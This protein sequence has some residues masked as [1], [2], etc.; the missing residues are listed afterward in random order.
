M[1]ARWLA[2][3]AATMGMVGRAMRSDS[4]VSMPSPAARMS[5]ATPKRTPCPRR[6]PIARRG[7]SIGALPD[8]DGS[9]QVRCDAGDPTSRDR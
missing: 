3:S 1:A 6:W 9:S 4:M 7:V 8:P 5:P 2:E